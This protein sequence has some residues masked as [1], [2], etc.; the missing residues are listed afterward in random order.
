MSGHYRC[1][2]LDFMRPSGSLVGLPNREA[3][4]IDPCGPGQLKKMRSRRTIR[5]D[6]S[7][8]SLGRPWS[9]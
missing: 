1:C 7:D 6:R 9:I 2:K 3:S 5:A 4:F 8:L